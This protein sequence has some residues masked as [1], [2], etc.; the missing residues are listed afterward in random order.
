MPA[1]TAWVYIM[2]SESRAIYTGV[3][4]NLERRVREHKTHYVVSSFTSQYD[5]TKLVSIEEYPRVDDA[6]TREKQLKGMRRA[7]KIALIVEKN[8][9]WNDL[10]WSWFDP[11]DIARD[12]ERHEREHASRKREG[13]SRH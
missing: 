10:A 8:P 13:A 9:R 6:I 7:K 12:R 3:T 4:T 11:A 5:V 2:A 1:R